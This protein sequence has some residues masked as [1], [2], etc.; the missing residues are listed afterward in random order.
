MN[1][2][3]ACVAGFHT[4]FF[5]FCFFTLM[6]FDVYLEVTLRMFKLDEGS[7]EGSVLG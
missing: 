3:Q 1:Q 5:L 2:M 6:L 4:V 7:L